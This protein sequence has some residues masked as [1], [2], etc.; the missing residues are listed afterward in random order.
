MDFD[1]SNIAF[2]LWLIKV[3]PRGSGALYFI[4]IKL[5]NDYCGKRIAPRAKDKASDYSGLTQINVFGIEVSILWVQDVIMNKIT[6]HT[7]GHFCIIGI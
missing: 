2:C 1:I 7:G 6:D 3:K 5:L 4:N